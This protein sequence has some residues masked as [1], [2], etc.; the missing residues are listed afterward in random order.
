MNEPPV[1]F[2]T[3]QAVDFLVSRQVAEFLVTEAAFGAVK[4]P[5]P[6]FERSDGGH[7]LLP[8]FSRLSLAR[9]AESHRDHRYVATAR[10]LLRVRFRRALPIGGIR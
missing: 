2:Q 1:F 6:D 3:H 5:H 10:L 9:C 8:W 7:G 4:A